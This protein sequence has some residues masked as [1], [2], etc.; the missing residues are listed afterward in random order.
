MGIELRYRYRCISILYCRKKKCFLPLATFEKSSPP[1]MYSMTKKIFCLVAITS[2]NSTT[3]G[4]LTNRMTEISRLI[5][6]IMPSFL[7]T[8]S[9]LIT[10]IATLSEVAMFL[11]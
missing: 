11:P 7:R 9:L 5:W 6:S 1:L 2:F 10:L 3:L 8:W 4:C